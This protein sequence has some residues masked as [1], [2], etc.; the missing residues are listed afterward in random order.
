MINELPA[1]VSIGAIAID[2]TDSWVRAAYQRRHIHCEAFLA[3]GTTVYIGLIAGA[4]DRYRAHMLVA[5]D[6][7]DAAILKM[8]AE[9]PLLVFIPPYFMS[10]GSSLASRFISWQSVL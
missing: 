2:Q 4:A 10:I 9:T 8:E 6:E 1:V 5:H 3:G 7:H